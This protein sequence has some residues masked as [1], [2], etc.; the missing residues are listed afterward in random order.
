MADRSTNRKIKKIFSL[1]KKMPLQWFLVFLYLF[2]FILCVD[3]GSSILLCVASQPWLVQLGFFPSRTVS[4]CWEREE[5]LQDLW[6]PSY[7]VMWYHFHPRPTVGAES[8]WVLWEK[9]S[10]TGITPYTIMGGA[11]EAKVGKR[12]WRTREGATS[13]RSQVHPASRWDRKGGAEEEF[14]TELPT[15]CICSQVSAGGLSWGSSG[16]AAR[17]KSG[18][19]REET[20]ASWNPLD[21]PAS[22]T[23]STKTF[24][25]N[26]CRIPSTFPSSATSSLPSSNGGLHQ[27]GEPGFTK[28]P[29]CKP[30]QPGH[31]GGQQS[32]RLE[33]RAVLTTPGGMLPRHGGGLH[34]TRQ[35]GYK[36]LQKRRRKEDNTEP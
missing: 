3:Q 33:I 2:F 15:P 13:Q 9:A 36:Q 23:P 30:S 17:G 14:N 4:G 5:K 7:E 19:Q 12:S 25:S 18:P 8:M 21:T 20:G 35:T 31:E 34:P 6:R 1:P 26:G 28:S 29:W 32:R 16:E 24:K 10:I 27:E 11:K 22:V